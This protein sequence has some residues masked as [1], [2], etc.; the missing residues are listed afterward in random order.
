MK[1]NTLLTKVILDDLMKMLQCKQNRIC[2][3]IGVTPN[4]L[5][6]NA[7]KPFSAIRKK[8]TGKR[9]L[10]LLYVVGE[11]SKDKSLVPSTIIHVITSSRYRYENKHVN[12]VTGIT[13]EFQNEFL[14]EIAKSVLA[15]L[16]KHD[17]QRE[18]P[19]PSLYEMACSA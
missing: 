9:L 15:D 6:A 14:L 4:T 2:S 5:S 8:K 17:V 13:L 1:N 10:S 7:K 18:Q 3:F 19:A 16:R 11:L 12:V